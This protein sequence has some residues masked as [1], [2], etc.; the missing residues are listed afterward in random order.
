MTTQG[1]HDLSVL[2]GQPKVAVRLKVLPAGGRKMT[3]QGEH[4]LSVLRGQPKVAVRHKVLP[5]G[6]TTGKLSQREHDW[7]VFTS[8]S[9]HIWK[10]L[11]HVYNYS[12]LAVSLCPPSDA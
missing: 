9:L 10:I 7:S 1:E 5:A 3:T 11:A 6:G 2:R 8:D 12:C 4:D